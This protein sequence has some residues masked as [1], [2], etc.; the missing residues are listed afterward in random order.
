MSRKKNTPWIGL[1]LLLLSD[2]LIISSFAHE[3]PNIFIVYVSK[4]DKPSIFNTHLD[5]YTSTLQ[6]LPPSPLTSSFGTGHLHRPSPEIIYTYNHAI[7]GFAARLTPS[8][9]SHLRSLHGVV[10]ISP[11]RT[12]RIYTTRTPQFLGLNDHSGLWP[13]SKHGENVIIGVIDSGIWPERQSFNDSGYTPVPERWKGICETG[14]DFPETSCNRKIIGARVYYKG[15]E[16]A[17]GMPVDADGTESRSPRDTHGHGTHCASIAAGSSVS[18]AGFRKFAVGVAKG[19][20][21]KARIAVYKVSWTFGIV[22]SDVIA[23]MDQAVADGVDIISLSLG[24]GQSMKYYDDSIAIAAFGAMQKG[25]LVSC[26]AGNNGPTPMSVD[27]LAPWMM[28]VGASTIDREF[29]ADLVLGDGQVF[30][31]AS[32][33]NGDPLNQQSGEYVE[34]V[35]SLRNK[36]DRYCA[37]G[38]LNSTHVSGKIV[39]CYVGYDT[40]AADQGTAVKT[41]GGVGMI[42][43]DRNEGELRARAYP[44]PATEVSL[45]S[46]SKIIEYMNKQ[47]SNGQRP[48]AT[49]KF[50]GMVTGSSSSSAPRVASLSS[51]GPSQIVPEI[52][53][54]DVIAPGI[55]ILAAWT[56]FGA[57]PANSEEFNIISGSSMACPH[58]S[59]LAALLRSAYPKWSPAAIKSALMTTAYNTDNSGR[60]ITDFATNNYSTPFQHGSGHVN[61]NKAL[62]PGLVYDIAPSDY[63]AFLCSIGYNAEQIWLFSKDKKVDCELLKPSTTGPGDLNYPSFSVV[64]GKTEN[65]KYKRVV[66]N[67][68]SSVNAVYNVRIR[69]RTSFVKISVSPTK[70][71]FTKDKTSLPYEITFESKLKIPVT[72]KKEAFGSIEWYDTEHVVRSPLA[73]A[74][75]ITNSTNF[76]SS[77]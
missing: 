63:L 1:L 43:I 45:S 17:M 60:Y 38:S 57:D 75:E 65:F 21:S 3:Q 18:N 22:T 77:S 32:L 15:Y 19:M 51:R 52:L 67:V 26:A 56:G 50:R 37:G 40:N 4:S 30:P 42:L 54:P 24:P 27:N 72:V 66:T 23:G 20:A 61:P 25:I 47:Y 28:N 41:A 10:S 11:E 55:N 46:G 13:S 73:F 7:H 29:P 69:G 48:T 62:N 16:E 44:I 8:Q 68:G 35:Y 31:G 36:T 5:W 53:K 64:F 70:L 71:V 33:Y 58:V 74:W 6:S 49:I 14:P 59:G 76:I 34:V 9:A 39:V 2:L 12:H